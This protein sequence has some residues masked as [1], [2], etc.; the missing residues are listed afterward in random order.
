MLEPAQSST[1]RWDPSCKCRLPNRIDATPYTPVPCTVLDP[2][3]GAGTVPLVALRLGRDAIGCE[4]NP[5]YADMARA[6]V[7]DDAPLFNDVQTA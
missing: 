3:S 5:E 2:F 4:L 1:L 7:R 6:R